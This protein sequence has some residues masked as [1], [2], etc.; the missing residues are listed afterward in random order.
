MQEKAQFFEERW[1]RERLHR[2]EMCMAALSPGNSV[3]QFC[4]QGGTDQSCHPFP[5]WQSLDPSP[6]EQPA[7][8]THSAPASAPATIPGAQ[9]ARGT[10]HHDII[11]TFIFSLMMNSADISI[12]NSPKSELQPRGSSDFFLESGGLDLHLSRSWATANL[13]PVSHLSRGLCCSCFPL[14]SPISHQLRSISNIQ[15]VLYIYVASYSSKQKLIQVCS[16]SRCSCNS[17]EQSSRALRKKE[18]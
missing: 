7:L 5:A 6:C 15:N 3:V 10:S 18:Y 16:C 17:P 13:E 8:C 1:G 11:H 4:T 9:A 12:Q 14:I 2:R